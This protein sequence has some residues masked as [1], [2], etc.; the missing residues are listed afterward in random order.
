MK[1]KALTAGALAAA[2]MTTSVAA[3][4]APVAATSTVR[5]GSVTTDKNELAGGAGIFAILIAAGVAAIG[6]IAIVKDDKS[7]SN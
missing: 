3:T 6:I 7:D 1:L 5:A 4:A 2:M